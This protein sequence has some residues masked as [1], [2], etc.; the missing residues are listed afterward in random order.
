MAFLYMILDKEMHERLDKIDKRL[1]SLGE[2]SAGQCS[3]EMTGTFLNPAYN[4]SHIANDHP[5]ATSG[6]VI[7]LHF[8]CIKMA[9]LVCPVAALHSR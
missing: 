2:L 4:C 1:E 3:Y 6:I 9:I 7:K 5:N 8:I